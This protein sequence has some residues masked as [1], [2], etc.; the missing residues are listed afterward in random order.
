MTP[1]Q[2]KWLDEI[3]DHFRF[4]RVAKMMRGMNWNWKIDEDFR[5]PC[6]S[7]MRTTAR[8]LLNYAILSQCRISSGGFTASCDKDGLTL[9][10]V[11]EEH[12]AFTHDPSPKPTAK[13]QARGAILP[14]TK[15]PGPDV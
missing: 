5:R 11:F 15:R 4:E 1:E 9:Q 7:E 3:M 13:Q 12:E 2:Q 14:A 6:V 10:F 8:R